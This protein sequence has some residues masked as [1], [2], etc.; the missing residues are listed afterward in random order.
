MQ[1]LFIDGLIRMCFYKRAVHTKENYNNMVQNIHC[2]LY[3]L[4][5]HFSYDNNRNNIDLNLFVC[6]YIYV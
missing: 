4:C 2:N 5:A 1:Y 3:T 6:V